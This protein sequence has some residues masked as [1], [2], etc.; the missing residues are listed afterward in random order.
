MAMTYDK[1]GG[2]TF[3]RSEVG[4]SGFYGHVL[5]DT[6]RKTRLLV[7]KAPKGKYQTL[8]LKVPEETTVFNK[9]PR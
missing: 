3:V 8:L 4:L 1:I 9:V 2:D 5:L 7:R 6:R